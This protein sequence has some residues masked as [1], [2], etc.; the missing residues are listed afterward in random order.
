VRRLDEAV[1]DLQKLLQDLAIDTNPVVVFTSDNG[2]TREDALGLSV[3]YEANFFDNFGPFDGL[4]RDT[5][6][7]GIRMPTLVRWPGRIPAGTS[8]QSP[9]QSHDWMPTFAD[10]AGLPAPARSDGVSLLP[11]LTGVGTQLPA[12]FT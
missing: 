10:L 8:S 7:G 1:G 5:L 6:E 12:R 11:T 2:P 3:R 9:S 4:K